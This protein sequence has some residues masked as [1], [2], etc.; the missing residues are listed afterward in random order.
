M[1]D[2]ANLVIAMAL[3]EGN[4]VTAPEVMNIVYMAHGTM[5]GVHHRPMLRQEIEAWQEG[6]TAPEL[7]RSLAGYQG[8]PVT[9]PMNA[10]RETYDEY[11]ERAVRAA[12]ELHKRMGSR[13]MGEM[14]TAPGSPWHRK[15]TNTK[16]ASAVIPQRDI[17][18][19][20]AGM[21]RSRRAAGSPAPGARSRMTEWRRRTVERTMLTI[22]HSNHTLET[23]LG[24]LEQNR[25]LQVIDVR[26]TPVSRH[27][28]HFS[29]DRIRT[30][31]EEAGMGYTHM[32]ELGGRP[33][34]DSLYNAQG[35]VQYHLIARTPAFQENLEIA[36]D[37][38]EER[39]AALMCTERDPVLCHRTLLV[40][41]Q[42]D[43]TGRRVDHIT[44]GGARIR[45]SDLMDRL[46]ESWPQC[47]GREPRRM[48]IKEA[49]ELQAAREGYSRRN[50]R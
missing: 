12:W 11:E 10:D 36:M 30:A 34:D 25:V 26:S 17:E 37:M 19:F 4:P 47:H 42:I 45:H 43:L 35:R 1:R 31:L 23:F 8:R 39:Q 50:G 41:Q 38:N 13:R 15:W 14:V 46:A 9:A 28:P 16:N 20:Y 29:R 6:P 40:A 24:L 18:A 5:L 22:G 2:V 33:R 49:V 48:R 44:G 21:A 7:R 3:R 27:A 32:G